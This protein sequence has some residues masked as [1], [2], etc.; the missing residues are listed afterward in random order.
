MFESLVPKP[1][2]PSGTTEPT[3][4]PSPMLARLA[5]RKLSMAAAAPALSRHVEQHARA[6]IGDSCPKEAVQTASTTMADNLER[7]G[8]M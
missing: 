2:V 7:L 4:R 3:A 1:S 5:T 6:M 8:A